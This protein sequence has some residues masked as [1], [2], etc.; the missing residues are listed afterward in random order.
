MCSRAARL[1]RSYGYR[2][3]EGKLSATDKLKNTRI[4]LAGDW[5]DKGKQTREIIQF[6]YNNQEHFL[7]VMGNHE[8][9]VYKYLRGRSRG[10][11]RSC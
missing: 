7:F 6:L 8:N 11:S 2:I 10:L 5:I 1:L 9:F 4:I 3:E